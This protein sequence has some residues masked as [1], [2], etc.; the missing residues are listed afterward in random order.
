MILGG[1]EGERLVYTYRAGGAETVF[2]PV[3]LGRP[4]VFATLNS[5]RWT[6]VQP[7][8]IEVTMD[9]MRGGTGPFIAASREIVMD[10]AEVGLSPIFIVLTKLHTSDEVGGATNL[11]PVTTFERSIGDGL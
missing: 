10:V 4:T 8:C 5:E 11:R 2:S 6:T 1:L 9:N 7:V 3:T